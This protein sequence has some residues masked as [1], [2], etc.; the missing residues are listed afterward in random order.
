TY[1][2]ICGSAASSS[3]QPRVAIPIDNSPSHQEPVIRSRNVRTAFLAGCTPSNDCAS[4]RSSRSTAGKTAKVRTCVV[5]EIRMNLSEHDDSRLDKI[6]L[7]V[8]QPRGILFDMDGV[9]YDD[10]RL[11][12]GAIETVEWLRARGIPHLFLTNTSSKPRAALAEKLCAFGIRA[13][14]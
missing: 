5:P 9:L 14:A 2:A 10:D 13:T 4:A 11:I 12:D 1:H 6:P 7:M 8:P 3:R